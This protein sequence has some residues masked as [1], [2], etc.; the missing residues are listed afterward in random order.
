MDIEVLR[1]YCL[2]KKAVTEG[3]P[4]DNET[5]VFKVAGK[6]FAI[7]PLE[8]G[9]RISLKCDPE[10][11]MEL[12]AEWEEIQPGWHLNKVHWNSVNVTGRLA[13]ELVR[14]LVDH[15]YELVV[16]GLTKKARAE[17]GL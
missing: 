11:A 14:D 4:F 16:K 17:H 6:M 7:I 2:A 3:F 12:R 10:R 1:E 5:L 13:P 9:D 8:H 15:S